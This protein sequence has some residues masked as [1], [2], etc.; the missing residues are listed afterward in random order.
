MKRSCIQGGE[1]LQSLVIVSLAKQF[2]SSQNEEKLHFQPS[3]SKCE[4]LGTVFHKTKVFLQPA[5][6]P[7]SGEWRRLL[8]KVQM[9]SLL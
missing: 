1:C 8:K 7:L 5:F 3:N 2:G 9:Q 6:P 4:V